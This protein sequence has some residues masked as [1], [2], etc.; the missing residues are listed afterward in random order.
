MPERRLKGRDRE[1]KVLHPDVWKETTLNAI[2]TRVLRTQKRRLLLCGSAYLSLSL[3]FFLADGAKRIPTTNHYIELETFYCFQLPTVNSL[4]H[5]P[6][7]LSKM[8]FY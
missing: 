2:L 5:S 7:N 3:Q 8:I 6:F 4:S 1:T